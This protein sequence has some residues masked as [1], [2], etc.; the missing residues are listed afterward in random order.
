MRP[1]AESP[2]A[3]VVVP[4]RVWQALQSPFGASLPIVLRWP[5]G[6]TTATP[7]R[8]NCSRVRPL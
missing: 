5:L 4:V 2:P 1:G 7:L 3:A 6:D 8:G